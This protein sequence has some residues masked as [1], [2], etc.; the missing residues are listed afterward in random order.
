V[1]WA[2]TPTI[3]PATA[4]TVRESSSQSA[5]AFKESYRHQLVG[6]ARAIAALKWLFMD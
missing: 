6:G 5:T 3:D 4:A 1:G 2:E